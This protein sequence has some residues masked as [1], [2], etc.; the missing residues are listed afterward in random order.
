MKDLSE[1]LDLNMKKY[2]ETHDPEVIKKCV[3]LASRIR[4]IK[5]EQIL[6]LNN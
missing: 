5:N 1:S 2:E 4:K 3:E 6:N